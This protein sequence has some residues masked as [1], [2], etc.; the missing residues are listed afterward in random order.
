MKIFGAGSIEDI[1][2]CNDL[3]VAG[4]LTNPQGFD[5][6]FQGKVTLEEITQAILKV[7]DVPI[8]IQIHG[9]SMEALVARARRLHRL[10][11]RVGFKILADEK[12][13]R[14]IREL[15][16]KQI[17]CIATCLFTVS[18][19]AVAA[20]VGAHGICLFISRARESGM[21]PFTTVKT[22]KEGYRKLPRA[23]EII[24]VSLKNLADVENAIAA[25]ADAVGMRYALIRD[26]MENILTRK[27]EALF[28]QNWANVKGEDPSY[29]KTA[30]PTAGLAE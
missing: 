2:K 15:E 28:A 23:P 25:G 12:G 14:A 9:E 26:L 1:K 30:P 8:F 24:A 7:S 19:A 18:Q 22:I 16:K 17:P 27:A 29:L 13:F 3:G 11:P 20:M 6:Y 21:D 10:S 5:Q 4:I